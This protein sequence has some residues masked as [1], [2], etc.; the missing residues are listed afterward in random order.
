M[1]KQLYPKNG[2]RHICMLMFIADSQQPNSGSNP[3]VH[4]QMNGK[5]ECGTLIQQSVS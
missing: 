2:K 4:R 3:R 1:I 5:T